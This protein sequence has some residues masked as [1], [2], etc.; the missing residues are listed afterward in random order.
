MG[1][2]RKWSEVPIIVLSARNQESEIT[3]AL[4]NR[5]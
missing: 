2:L 5:C 3:R 1:R 4:D